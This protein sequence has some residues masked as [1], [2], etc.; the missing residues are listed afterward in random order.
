MSEA[1]KALLAKATKRPW[2]VEPRQDSN[3]LNL[4]AGPFD[5]G[6]GVPLSLQVATIHEHDGDEVKNAALIAIAVN[7]LEELVDL[8]SHMRAVCDKA[9]WHGPLGAADRL[10]AKIEAAAKETP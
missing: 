8:V 4:L 2:R 6:V 3:R 5:F 1:L 9:G 10:L 7:H